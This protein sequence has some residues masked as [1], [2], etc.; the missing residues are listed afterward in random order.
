MDYCKSSMG[1][2]SKQKDTGRVRREFDVEYTVYQRYGSTV[3]PYKEA[4]RIEREGYGR[5]YTVTVI[6]D[7]AET[8]T[9]VSSATMDD[10]GFVAYIACVYSRRYASIKGAEIRSFCAFWE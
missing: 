4:V 7:G 2:E 10:V 1:R 9:H 3:M 5:D 8:V 6:A